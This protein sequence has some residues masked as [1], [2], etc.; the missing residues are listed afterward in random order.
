[1]DQ[2]YALLPTFCATHTLS[3]GKL[4]TP[5]PCPDWVEV[6]QPKILSALEEDLNHLVPLGGGEA[7]SH[8]GAIVF[9][10]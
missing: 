3:I 2:S 10:N 1:M 6:V 4:E 9:D 5:K 7:T 8:R